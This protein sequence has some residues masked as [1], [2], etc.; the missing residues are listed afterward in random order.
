MLDSMQLEIDSI[1]GINCIYIHGHLTYKHPLPLAQ[2][3]MTSTFAQEESH[4]SFSYIGYG[5]GVDALSQASNS[6]I[7]IASID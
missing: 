3:I 1:S 2:G 6:V 5:K 7:W 4:I